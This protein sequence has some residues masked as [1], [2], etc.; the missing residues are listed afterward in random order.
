MRELLEQSVFLGLTDHTFAISLDSSVSSENASK[1]YI[2]AQE[3]G[4]SLEVS[5]TLIKSTGPRWS[6]TQTYLD[7]KVSPDTIFEDALAFLDRSKRDYGV[8]AALA[9]VI[10]KACSRY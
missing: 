10:Y 5:L 2:E 4:A 9:Q 6:M 8:H 1:A 7:G 3:T